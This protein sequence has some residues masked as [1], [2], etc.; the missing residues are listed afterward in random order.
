MGA[1]APTSGSADGE[2]SPAYSRVVLKLSG[3]AL[4]GEEPYGI[5]PER[6]QGATPTDWSEF[7]LDPTRP[8]ALLVGLVYAAKGQDLALE[9][10][11]APGLEE[12]QLVCAGPGETEALEA[13]IRRLDLGPRVR[14]LGA[15]R[16]AAVVGELAGDHGRREHVARRRVFPAR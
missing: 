3:E 7:G 6:M 11:G 8:T 13:Q 14:L 1:D 10:L 12:L 5:D 4:M 16:D 2:G 9:A 15:R